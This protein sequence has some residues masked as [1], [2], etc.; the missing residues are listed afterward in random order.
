MTLRVFLLAFT[1]IAS[2]AGAEPIDNCATLLGSISI[3]LRVARTL[4]ASRRTT[5]T[6]PR[7]T[8]ALF[9]ATKQRIL[10]SLG[11]PDASGAI[12]DSPGAASWSYF[13][14]GR[15]EGPRE[16][17]VPQL[18]FNFDEHQLV[19]SIDCQLTQ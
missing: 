17:A 2:S 5:F 13:F 6:C 18:T 10:N 7:N 15:H 8:S 11:P 1:A 19:G 12:E 16:F 14:E 4:P 3:E 9:G